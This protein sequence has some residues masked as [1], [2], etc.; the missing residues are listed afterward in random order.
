MSQALRDQIVGALRIL[1]PVIL[2]WLSA[3]GSITSE[4]LGGIIQAASDAFV[5]LVIL[6][7]MVWSVWAHREVKQIES[8]SK[9]PSV[10]K[11]VA[12]PKVADGP[13]LKDNPKVVSTAE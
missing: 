10:E 7:S 2:T 9:M 6:V 4:T 5:A 1:V 8:A 11:I 13:V 3:N 12:T